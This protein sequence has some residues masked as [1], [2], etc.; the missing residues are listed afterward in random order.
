MYLRLMIG[1]IDTLVKSFYFNESVKLV[2]HHFF[3]H[4]L[5]SYDEF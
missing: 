2:F 4:E 5:I 1:L 3:D